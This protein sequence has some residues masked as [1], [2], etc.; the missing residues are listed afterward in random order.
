MLNCDYTLSLKVN[1][2]HK[3]ARTHA[4]ISVYIVMNWLI[5][6]IEFEKKINLIKMLREINVP[7]FFNA[8]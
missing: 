3:K 8:I 7:F 6:I 4:Y 1:D 5:K 2:A